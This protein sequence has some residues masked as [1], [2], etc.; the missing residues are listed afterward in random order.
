MSSFDLAVFNGQVDLEMVERL[1]PGGFMDWWTDR[2]QNRAAKCKGQGSGGFA[3]RGRIRDTVETSADDFALV[4]NSR[5]EANIVVVRISDGTIAV[6]SKA[7]GV[8]SEN[9]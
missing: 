8:H 7:G 2:P 5:D 4:R 1:A 3:V 9:K 6:E